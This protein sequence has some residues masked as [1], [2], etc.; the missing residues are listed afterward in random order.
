MRLRYLSEAHGH[1]IRDWWGALQPKTS[2]EKKT[3]P[4]LFALDRGDRAR[5]KR[6][7]SVEELETERAANLL[8]ARLQSGEWKNH[9]AKNR[10]DLDA[11]AVLMAAGVLAA[12][13]ADKH[14]GKSLAWH[15]GAASAEGGENS[16]MSEMR[17]KRMLQAKS[18]EDFFPMARRAVQLANRT[19]KDRGTVDVVVLADDL[20]AWVYEQTLVNGS[21]RPANSLCFRW[22]QDYYQPLKDKDAAWTTTEET[23]QGEMA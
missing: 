18:I 21:Q 10:F 23:P 13:K 1:W 9:L 14:D 17:F 3:S 7:N 2:S 4:E 12:V 15:V 6:A 16:P 8:V 5:L 22:A 19:S 20:L 11:R